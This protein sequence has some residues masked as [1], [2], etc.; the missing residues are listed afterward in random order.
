MWIVLLAFCHGVLPQAGASRQPQ[1]PA[2]PGG[3][4]D[5]CAARTSQAAGLDATAEVTRL[6]ACGDMA[7]AEGDS[8]GALQAYVAS[9]EAA[10][11]SGIRALLAEALQ[12]VGDGYL[13]LGDGRRA[14]EHYA[15]GLAIA[16]ADHE[17]KRVASLIS[18]TGRLRVMQGRY[19][20]ALEAHGRSLAL[21]E[22]I[23]DERG[24]A[25]SS[26]NVGAVL[27]MQGNYIDALPYFERSLAA[28]E[29]LQDRRGSATVIDNIAA[30]N[31]E[32]GDH[33]VAL[34]LG[35]R[36]LAIRE[37]LGDKVG[38][39]KSFD[40]LSWLY[41]AQGNYS[42]ALEAQHK[43]L[44][45]RRSAGAA[46]ATAESLNNIA[47]VYRSQGDYAQAARYLRQALAAART[48]GNPALE[49]EIHTHAGALHYLQGDH[50]LALRSLGEALRITSRPEYRLKAAE[51]RF[52]IGRVYAAVGRVTDAEDA[53]R[54]SLDFARQSGSRPMVASALAELADVVRQRGRGGEALHLAREATMLAAALE[55]PEIHWRALT[56][57][58]RIHA[59]SG[60]S[61]EAGQAFD[62]A[63]AIIEDLRYRVAGPD[64][65]RSAFL[66]TRLAPYQE[67]VALA[68]SKSD[69]RS[70]FH[71]A[72][73][74]KARALLDAF[75]G[76]RPALRTAMSD[77][78]RRS[79]MQFVRT[80]NSLNHQV[81]AAAE[82]ERPD[83]GRL[84]ALRRRRAAARLEYE[85]FQA[86]LYASRPEL[87]V[88]R[89]V[90]EA[91]TVADAQRLL[92]SPE[93]A[94]VEY[95]AGPSGA[96]AFVITTTGVRSLRLAATLA[97]LERQIHT[98]RSQLAARDLRVRDTARDLYDT[99]LAPLRP[100]LSGKTDLIIVSD[101]FLWELPFQALQSP[102]GR[103]LIEDAAVAYAPSITI[104]RETMKLRPVRRLQPSVLAFGNPELGGSP[105]EGTAS[106]LMDG[107]LR[108]LP[109]AE[110]QVRGLARVY[111]DRS[112]VYT[113]AAATEEAWKAE[114][115]RHSVLQLATHGV[116][117]DR[118]PLYSFLVLARP[119]P[120]SREDGLLEAWEVMNLRLD[121]DLVVLSACET[122]RGRV[123]KGEG[124]IGLM[125]AFLVAGSPATLVTQWKVESASSTALMVNFHEGW[126]GGAAG[127]SKARALQRGVQQL[128]RS[129]DHAHPFH[130]AGYILVGDP[131]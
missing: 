62:Q 94:I 67:R 37:E 48:L 122:G 27:R 14:E 87:R 19:E 105:R 65:T 63:M 15:E 13:Q 123:S 33:E 115:A 26:N 128:L 106:S 96:W 92:G 107:R 91:A 85:D 72:E 77:D 45:L 74:S 4:A 83:A 9:L 7:E 97:P 73:R 38:V 119:G 111:A 64:A 101:G 116:L 71:I 20:D 124:V 41:L 127:V 47:I 11:G 6:L 78:E 84:T 39:G 29:R 120:G 60:R 55:L 109:D 16:E 57:V 30:A 5:G 43:S 126:V 75:G 23:N 79:E 54:Q 129:G 2:R 50:A 131:R 98:F 125:W 10:R 1:E 102:E 28:L 40:S 53:F 21:Y 80:L 17:R 18:S 70:A 59:A 46:H 44:A 69:A 34:A 3:G 24:L 58:G 103:Y 51:A 49:A 68:L 42:A 110:E 56:A 12:A 35:E 86:R 82:A 112:R 31:R 81:L 76:G 113:G 22:A 52:A 118:N 66:E 25:K 108:P 117:D 90:F 121:A 100:H 89:G 61:E 88:E 93:S 32:L 104:L 36:A 8:R 114:A 99:L 95:V 130:W